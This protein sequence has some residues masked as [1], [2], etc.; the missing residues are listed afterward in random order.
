R[1]TA[2]DGVSLAHVWKVAI[3]IGLEQLLHGLDVAMGPVA[4][5]TLR[6]DSF[7]ADVQ[8]DRPALHYGLRG[9]G[10]LEVAGRRSVG[11]SART[12]IVIA[13]RAP[14]SDVVVASVEMRVRYQGL[15]GVFDHLHEPLV[16]RVTAGDPV[17]RT[18]EELLQEVDAQRPGFYAMAEALLRRCVIWLLRRCFEE[19]ERRMPWLA[20]LE[21]ARP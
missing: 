9:A 17:R 10:R 20:P 5:H 7:L 18:F 3:M 1:A 6:R 15:V 12:L 21:A 2:V 4:I 16:E 14:E 8:T 13:N 19:S 11:I